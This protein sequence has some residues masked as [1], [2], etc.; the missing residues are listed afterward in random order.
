M[1]KG[2]QVAV[3]EDFGFYFILFIKY[4]SGP[5]FFSFSFGTRKMGS[6]FKGMRFDKFVR[7]KH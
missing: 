7:F 5:T 6:C 3:V 4:N 2:W 1:P